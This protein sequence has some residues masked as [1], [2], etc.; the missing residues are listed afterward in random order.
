VPLANIVLLSPIVRDRAECGTVGGSA[1]ASCTAPGAGGP[2]CAG[3]PTTRACLSGTSV[4]KAC[5]TLGATCPGGAVCADVT[6]ACGDG[7]S[8]GDPGERVRMTLFLQNIS[9]FNLTGITLSLSTADPDIQCILDSTIQIAS[10]PNG[11]TLNT[12]SLTPGD[13]PA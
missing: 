13:D 8:F 11:T 3:G 10:F 6:G 1:A 2:G 7:D 9:G 5:T 12:A 4:G